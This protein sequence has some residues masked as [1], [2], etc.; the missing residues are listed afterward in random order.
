MK[1]ILVSESDDVA[2]GAT[3][4]SDINVENVEVW[5]Q[6]D[7]TACVNMLFAI[8][9]DK[10]LLRLMAEHMTLQH[11]NHVNHNKSV[12]DLLGRGPKAAS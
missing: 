8:R 11:N 6:R 5:L 9:N 4:V 3:N 1:K 12:G 10:N 7:I 2:P